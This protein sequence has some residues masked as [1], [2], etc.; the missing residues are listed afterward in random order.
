ML[1]SCWSL[2]CCSNF[3]V[4]KVR[5][6]SFYFKDN[7]HFLYIQFVAFHINLIVEGMFILQIR[8]ASFLSQRMEYRVAV[9]RATVSLGFSMAHPRCVNPYG[10]KRD[11]SLRPVNPSMFSINWVV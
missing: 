9:I 1:D 11:W 3:S 5:N 10:L 4:A 6:A 2:H 7:T 8:S